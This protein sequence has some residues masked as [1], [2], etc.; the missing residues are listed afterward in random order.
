MSRR[1]SP[2]EAED[3]ERAVRSLMRREGNRY[4]ADCGT[5]PN[6]RLLPLCTFVCAMCSG[7]HRD[8][9]RRV[10]HV[11]SRM[12]TMDD[13]D[14]VDARGGNSGARQ[15]W[16]ARWNARE[17]PEPPPG[18]VERARE[19]IWLKYEGS[20][21]A[22]P[23][24]SSGGRGGGR[25][26]RDDFRRPPIVDD[27][28]RRGPPPGREQE[29]DRYP[30]GRD[31]RDRDPYGPPPPRRGDG[32]G[33]DPYSRE[34]G[35]GYGEPERPRRHRKSSS[36]KDRKKGKKKGKSSKRADSD[37]SESSRSSSVSGSDS[38][39]SSSGSDSD[40]ARRRRRR[41]KKAGADKSRSKSSKDKK[42]KKKASESSRNGG[43]RPRLREPPTTSWAGDCR[44]WGDGASAAL[45]E[46]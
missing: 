28:G 34:R 17:F 3:A 13:V 36:T 41:A 32:Y 46:A 26:E 11:D 6:A 7:I 20:W 19:F 24:T 43:R 8:A 5:V 29:L 40:E 35:G 16:M 27:F 1:P 23:P 30:G 2:R 31:P 10:K 9:G 4:C 15:K 44:V 45:A 22:R 18:D 25:G 21:A 37:S 12:L 42:K 33:D 14:R 39:A 38:D